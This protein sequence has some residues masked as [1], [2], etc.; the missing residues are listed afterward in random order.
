M[1]KKLAGIDLGL[2]NPVTLYDGDTRILRSRLDENMLASMYFY[3]RKC[4]DIQHAMDHKFNINKARHQQNPDWPLYSKRYRKLQF[5]FRR[6]HK[7]IVYI[8]KNWICETCDI[9]TT[10]YKNIVVDEF[11]IP[12]ANDSKT[13]ST[14]AK[15]RI[16]TFNRS[17]AM[18]NFMMTLRHDSIKNGCKHFLAPTETTLTCSDCG[19]KVDPLDLTKIMFSCPNCGLYVDRDINA[20]INCYNAYKKAAINLTINENDNF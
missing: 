6:Y 12:N 3:D 10:N 18:Y 4:R 11:K 5:R 1:R 2:R 16:N 9:I 19:A 20:A 15:Q 14:V 8:R 7:K 13:L 17:H